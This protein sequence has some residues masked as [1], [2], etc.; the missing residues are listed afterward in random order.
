MIGVESNKSSSSGTGSVA[1]PDIT[2]DP[3]GNIALAPYLDSITNLE[4]NEFK[5]LY[6]QAVSSSSGT[7]TI[8][9]GGTIL[10]G[11]IQGVDSL[12]ETI[13][14]GHPTGNSPITSGGSPVIVTSFDIGGNYVLSGTP[15]AYPV[16]V[17]FVLLVKGKDIYN[18]TQSQVIAD[19]QVGLMVGASA[20]TDGKSGQVTKPVAG[21]QIKV[22]TGGGVWQTIKEIMGYI[23][24]SIFDT[25][26]PVSSIPS[27]VS[28]NIFFLSKKI[29]AGLLASKLSTISIVTQWYNGASSGSKTIRLYISPNPNLTGAQLLGFFTYSGSSG[30]IFFRTCRIISSTLIL[31]S[32]IN[33]TSSSGDLNNNPLNAYPVNMSVDNYIILTV[34]KTN[35]AD[36]FDAGYVSLTISTPMP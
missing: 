12:V 14:S 30:V 15:S 23:P 26:A 25:L 4:N 7:V 1:F 19:E 28:E 36:G 34:Q 10:L 20:S 11:E 29:D 3:H 2:G 24:T 33:T 8:P 16:A 5:Y 6:W 13:A 22:L 21:D 18:L 9:T 32:T 35:A 27:N 31:P 17:L